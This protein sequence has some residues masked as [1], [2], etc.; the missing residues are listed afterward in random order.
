MTKAKPI[1]PIPTENEYHLR[2]KIIVKDHTYDDIQSTGNR[3]RV[4]RK[5]VLLLPVDSSEAYRFF[6]AW[7]GI[8][9]KL[10]EVLLRFDHPFHQYARG[11]V[12]NPKSVDPDQS[13]LEA[14][15]IFLM[16][17]GLSQ[18]IISKPYLWDKEVDL[19]T[20]A[21]SDDHPEGAPTDNADV[22][23]D[24]LTFEKKNIADIGAS[25]E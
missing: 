16:S 14:C 2:C 5:V 15:H 8:P 9:G 3:G 24:L 19:V 21:E 12:L 13:Q 18:I 23:D 4:T 11:A 20:L 10:V 7:L 25:G 1:S 6:S 22:G 17:Y